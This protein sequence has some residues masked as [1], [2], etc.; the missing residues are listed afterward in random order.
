MIL[1]SMCGHMLRYNHEVKYIVLSSGHL[2]YT[3][4]VYEA[5]ICYMKNIINVTIFLVFVCLSLA[6]VASLV[7][8]QGSAN[9][10]NKTSINATKINIV[11]VHGLWAD[12]HT[13]L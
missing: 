5:V 11:L 9:A 7:F 8:C 13:C 4:Y 6:I 2:L 1:Q 10:Q 12:A 3:K